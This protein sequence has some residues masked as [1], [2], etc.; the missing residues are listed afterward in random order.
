MRGN[1]IIS[2]TTFLWNKLD[3]DVGIFCCPKITLTPVRVNS[4]SLFCCYCHYSPI[5]NKSSLS[6]GQLCRN[7]RVHWPPALPGF[8]EDPLFRCCTFKAAWVHMQKRIHRKFWSPNTCILNVAYLQCFCFDCMHQ[9]TNDKITDPVL[10]PLTDF[11][12]YLSFAS[13]TAT[14]TTEGDNLLLGHHILQVTHGPF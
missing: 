1:L 6:V 7:A 5:I 11:S 14:E 2:K 9:N 4:C 13:R 3:S 12:S 10:L 8:S